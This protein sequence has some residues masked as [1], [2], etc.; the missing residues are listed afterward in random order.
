MLLLR[1]LLLLPRHRRL[2]YILLAA[3][4]LPPPPPHTHPQS[5]GACA[6]LNFMT[7]HGRSRFPGLFI[8][9]RDGKRVLVRVPPGCLLIQVRSSA[10]LLLVIYRHA[11]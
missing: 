11:C 8:W 7:I 9:T 10:E 1:R 5:Y 4:S 6:D 3:S 2:L